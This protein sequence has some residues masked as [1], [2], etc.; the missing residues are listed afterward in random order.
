MKVLKN[1]FHNLSYFVKSLKKYIMKFTQNKT[2]V[3]YLFHEMH[4]MMKVT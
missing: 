4:G 1:G 3:K 2:I